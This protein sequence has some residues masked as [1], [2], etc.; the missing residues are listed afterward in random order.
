[1]LSFRVDP[2]EAA[3]TREM[4]EALGIPQSDCVVNFDTIHTLPRE[5]FR[6]PVAK[7]TPVRLEEACQ[8][9]KAATGC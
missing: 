4:A 3:R 9:L 7:L 8:T 5:S 2:S 1:M 6:R